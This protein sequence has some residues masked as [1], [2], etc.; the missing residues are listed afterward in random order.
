MNKIEKVKD[1][2]VSGIMV[3]MHRQF[4]YNLKGKR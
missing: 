2:V 1:N 3:A 4:C